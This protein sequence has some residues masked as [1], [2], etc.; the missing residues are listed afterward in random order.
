MV[1]QFTKPSLMTRIAIGKAIGLVVGLISA[2]A[3][4][5][6]FP[7]IDVM[8]RI[9]IL[10]WYPTMGAFIGVFGVM[11]RHPVLDL[12]LP[13]WVRAPL[14]GAWM[15]LVL[16]FFA[17]QVMAGVL[18]GMTGIALSPFWFVLEGAV[19]G[20]LIG[21]VATRFGGE[22]AA[23]LKADEQERLRAQTNQ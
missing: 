17:H 13:W 23:S 5:A 12:P 10:L 11:T 7:E 21:F 8:T 19:V 14:I 4:P 9:G 18:A 3:T 2:L 15:N 22:G 1:N 20:A 6:F 16:V